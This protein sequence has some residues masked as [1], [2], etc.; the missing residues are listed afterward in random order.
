MKKWYTW[1][2]FAWAALVS[3]SRVYL[4]VH[5]PGDVT[6]GAIL[7]LVAG[8]GLAMVAKLLLKRMKK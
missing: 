5:Y 6:G 3:Y 1:S 4:G 7:G 2:I 8:T